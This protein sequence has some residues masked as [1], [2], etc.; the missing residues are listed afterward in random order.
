MMKINNKFKVVLLITTILFRINTN[1]QT[2][3]KK[4]DVIGLKRN[5]I[6]NFN[7]YTLAKQKPKSNFDQEG[8]NRSVTKTSF[9]GSRNAYGLIVTESNCLTANQ[10]LNAVMFTHRISSFFTLPNDNSGYVQNTFSTNLGTTWDSII[11]TSDPV[12]LCRYPSGAIFNP[13]GNTSINNAFATVSGPITSGSG[14]IGNY[15]S[16]AKLDSTN[17]NPSFSIDG[18]P[19]I[20][21]QGF[22]RIGATAT[23]SKTI[24]TGGLYLDPNGT[25][26]ATQ[27]YRGA[28]INYATPAGNNTFNW[29]IDS[30]KPNWATDA[31]GEPETYTITQTAWNKA[32]NIGYVVFNGV[33][34]SITISSAKGYAPIVYKTTDGGATWNLLPSF[35]FSTIPV[36]AQKLDPTWVSADG[37]STGPP[38]AWFTQDKGYDCAV[39]ENGNLHIFCVILSGFTMSNDSLGF[40]NTYASNALVKTFYMYD[41]FTTGSGWNSTMVDSLNTDNADDFSPFTDDTGVQFPVDAR[42][43]MSRSDDGSKLFF[44]WLDSDPNINNQV[45]NDQPNIFGKAFDVTTGLW[46]LTKQ[47]TTDNTNYFMYVSNLTLL[48]G[49]TYKVPVTVSLPVDWPNDANL[50]NPMRHYFVNGI[51]FDQSEFIVTKNFSNSTDDLYKIGNISPNPANNNASFLLNLITSSYVTIDI[52]DAIGTKVVTF[53]KGQLS[54]GEHK[55]DLDVSTLNAGI[56]FCTVTAGSKSISNKMIVKH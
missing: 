10:Q 19:G 22:A 17:I 11:Q 39:D 32:G 54:K 25:T 37:A 40:T 36:I 3:P 15:F 9:T 52:C 23:D 43:Q 2:I 48:S 56:Y 26:T 14:W 6:D 51:E 55:V 13:I 44:F 12:N 28:A 35:N 38:K 49:N 45:E 21:K 33:E 46:T 30:I 20:V 5:H 53:N 31:T 16:S 18:S 1:A 8:A 50:I 24:V 27:G 4:Q 29:T 7:F 41:T 34:A 47:F 42:L